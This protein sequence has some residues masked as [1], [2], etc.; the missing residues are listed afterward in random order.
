VTGVLQRVRG[1]HLARNLEEEQKYRRVQLGAKHGLEDAFQTL[2]V[3]MKDPAIASQLR[4][5]EVYGSSDVQFDR[6]LEFNIPSKEPR[7]LGLDDLDRLKMTVKKAGFTEGN[8]AQILLHILLHNPS[9]EDMYVILP[10]AFAHLA[11]KSLTNQ[12][13]RRQYH[14]S[15]DMML[16]QAIA[17]LFI[18]IS[19]SLESLSVFPVGEW[20]R[21]IKTML[22]SH[23]SVVQTRPKV[24][25]LISR[26][27]KRSFSSP[28]TARRVMMASIIIYASIIMSD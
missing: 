10:L 19:P 11:W 23:Y 27:S 16:K 17:A 25:F 28:I 20:S 24:H 3:F 15:A 4:Q 5:L 21:D 22:Y 6:G 2:L 9:G 18:T 13:T 7:Q 1:I 8:E 14:S 12:S 26:T